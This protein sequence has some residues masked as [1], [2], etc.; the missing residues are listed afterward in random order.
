MFGWLFAAPYTLKC[1]AVEAP[2]ERGG[3]RQ[4]PCGIAGWCFQIFD[5]WLGRGAGVADPW[6]GAHGA[7]AAEAAG[8]S[9]A[10]AQAAAPS[11]AAA[12]EGCRPAHGAGPG[13]LPTGSDAL[14]PP[15]AARAGAPLPPPADEA[16][17]PSPRPAKSAR[18]DAEEMAAALVPSSWADLTESAASVVGGECGA[19]GSALGGSL[20]G[21][22]GGGRDHEGGRGGS[23]PAAPHQR[24]RQA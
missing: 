23:E 17:A 7:E 21:E 20:S 15:S 16:A 1:A 11:P 8:A 5:C 4:P 18:Q 6:P 3:Y 22:S 24:G 9:A 14:L 19:A 2:A 13:C 12:A 10:A